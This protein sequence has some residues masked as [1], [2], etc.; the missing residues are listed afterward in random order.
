MLGQ[1]TH[2]ASCE[3]P[4]HTL[5]FLF[6]VGVAFATG[7]RIAQSTIVGFAGA[8]AIGAV[9]ILLPQLL[10]EEEAERLAFH[11]GGIRA[12]IGEWQRFYAWRDVAAIERGRHAMTIYLANLK[13][14]VVPL[15]AFENPNESDAT[16][17]ALNALRC[18]TAAITA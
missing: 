18:G 2:E 4:K 1:L 15:S 6:C 9:D 5:A 8:I 17:A 7:T 11:P 3:S 10:F 14:F 12:S 13:A 16:V